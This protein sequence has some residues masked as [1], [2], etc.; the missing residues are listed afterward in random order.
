MA[1]RSGMNGRQS[2]MRWPVLLV[3]LLAVALML[4][5]WAPVER[6]NGKG[7]PEAP[8]SAPAIPSTTPAPATGAPAQQ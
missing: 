1:Q 4:L 3:L 7:Q 6:F 8:V 2:W 5:V